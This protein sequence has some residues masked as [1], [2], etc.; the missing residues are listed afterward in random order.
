MTKPRKNAAVTYTCTTKDCPSEPFQLGGGAARDKKGRPWCVACYAWRRRWVR[1]WRLANPTATHEPEPP[2]R[3]KAERPVPPGTERRRLVNAYV[4]PE[5]DELL[6]KRQQKLGFVER[7]DFMV[8]VLANLVGREDLGPRKPKKMR[9]PKAPVV[10][11]E[12]QS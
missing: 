1:D 2:A 11:P 7:H 4:L 10:T 6:T 9:K 5:L 12:V 3:T 8:Y